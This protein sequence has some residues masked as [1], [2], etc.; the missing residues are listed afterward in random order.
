MSSLLALHSAFGVGQLGCKTPS[1]LDNFSRLRPRFRATSAQHHNPFLIPP[2][3]TSVSIY[4]YILHHIPF[5]LPFTQPHWLLTL[6]KEIMHSDTYRK[7]IVSMLKQCGRPHMGRPEV[8]QAR[9][10]RQLVP[11]PPRL[12]GF[13]CW[14]SGVDSDR[15]GP[16]PPT[17]ACWFSASKHRCVFM[18]TPDSQQPRPG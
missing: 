10:G 4:M 6:S 18:S 8:R 14:L 15:A 9:S 2:S 12:A 7:S 1:T 17:Q 5:H 16:P 3:M 11:A 13:C